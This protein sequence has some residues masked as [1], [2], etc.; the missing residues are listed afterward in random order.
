MQ[1]P[2][3]LALLIS[4]TAL[5]SVLFSQP[6][7]LSQE[8]SVWFL[9]ERFIITDSNHD[10]LLAREEMQA[11]P[12]EFCYYLADENFTASDRNV[13]GML[14][15][16]EIQARVKTE[17]L[18]RYNRDRRQLRQLAMEY[19]LMAQGEAAYY[20]QHPQLVEALF[21]NFVWLCE[22]TE[23]AAR[24]YEDGFWTAAHPE[25]LVALHRNLRWMTSNPL[26]AKKIYAE[27]NATRRVPELV[28]W[29]ADHQDFMRRHPELESFYRLDFLPGEVRLD[30]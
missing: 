19:P 29:R 11:L 30:R 25:V 23:L 2:I 16:N 10:A 12:E 17:F 15:F 1:H 5:T 6:L 13:D 7:A 18:F 22:H 27:R 26:E 24:L 20:R 9:E 28:A 3:R 14:S 4:L 21:G 8:I